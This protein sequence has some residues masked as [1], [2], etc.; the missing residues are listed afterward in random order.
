MY[1]VFDKK[2]P[3]RSRTLSTPSQVV[4]F[5]LGRSLTEYIVIKAIN[6]VN[7]VI[8]L[9]HCDIASVERQLRCA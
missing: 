1:H 5:L 6:G 3:T 7:V 9:E 2:W 4:S 8:P